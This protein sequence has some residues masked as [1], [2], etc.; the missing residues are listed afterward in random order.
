MLG[1]RVPLLARAGR[2]AGARISVRPTAQIS[3]PSRKHGQ[4][5]ASSREGESVGS[6]RLRSEGCDVGL[7]RSRLSSARHGSTWLG[8][9]VGWRLATGRLSRCLRGS[10]CLGG[11]GLLSFLGCCALWPAFS[12]GGAAR[13]ITAELRLALRHSFRPASH[14]FVWRSSPCFTCLSVA[15]CACAWL[16]AASPGCAWACLA[17]GKQPGGLP[18]A[19]AHKHHL[20]RYWEV[21]SDGMSAE[22]LRTLPTGLLAARHR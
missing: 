1:P 13:R 19:K 7:A 17:V 9:M 3:W 10:G 8:C 4:A 15:A 2:G 12:F 11:V 21:S 22:A 14:E 6:L 18:R 20:E 16:P 5:L